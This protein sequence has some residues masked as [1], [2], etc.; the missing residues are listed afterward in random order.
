LEYNGVRQLTKR[1]DPLGRVTLFQWCK[2]GDTKS[3]TDPL[4]RTTTWHH[5][6]QRRIS[7]KQ[8][9]DG[10]KTT[11]LYEATTSRVRQVIDEKGQVAQY[12][13]TAD[14]RLSSINFA[15]TEVP[16]APVFF[17][18]DP[19]Y[20]R[21]T[22]MTDGT[23]TTFYTYVPV[24]TSP[25][26]GAAQTESIDGPLPNERIL[27]GYDQLGRRVSASV[28]GVAWSKTFD[29]AGRMIGQTNALGAFSYVYDGASYRP[30]LEV[31]PNAQTNEMAY[32]D[33]LGDNTLRRITHRIAG[34]PVS[35]FRYTQDVPAGRIASWSQ[36][37]DS[38]QPSV[39]GLEYDEADQLRSAYLTNAG[40]LSHSYAYSY[41]L[42][43]N[44]LAEQVD[45]ST[46]RASY[47]ALNQ[48]SLANGLSDASF[49]NEWDAAQRLSAVSFGNQ[50]TEFTYDG[51]GRLVGL[52]QLT[53]GSETSNRLFLWSDDAVLGELTTDGRVS[54][55]FFDQ[56]VKVEIGPNPGLFF[57]TRDH[58][59]SVRELT[60][61][62]GKIRAR[63]TYD[64]F[65]RRSRV[66][67]DAEADFGFAGMFLVSE[68]GLY[69][70]RFRMYDPETGRWL[71]RDP[72]RN[73]EVQQGFNLYTYV[74]NN[75][76]NEVDRLGL[77]CDDK[78][79]AYEQAV[80]DSDRECLFAFID[81]ST[82]C[83]HAMYNP[84]GGGAA[85]CNVLLERA[86]RKCDDGARKVFRAQTELNA[87]LKEP[88]NPGSKCSAPPPRDP[89]SY[90]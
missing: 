8:F 15:N 56:G 13:Y 7:D 10:S 74:A 31:F 68:A 39:F 5:D 55:R 18:Y 70:T 21:E 80:E 73:A 54:K 57:Y 66:Q 40:S 51:R 14:D 71:S 75:P 41:D 59:D 9:T 72:L 78:K 53:N 79:R 90:F 52:R 1:T 63:Y 58:L 83:S 88:C 35:E 82:D 12:A 38:Q 26:L 16:T 36:Q 85:Y 77:C 33:N 24:T 11:Y 86:K 43:G 42:S 17:T 69:A 4:G 81:F 34:I 37:A 60:D 45:N 76:I 65:G 2:C 87:C 61:S 28:N 67:G 19:S 48:V 89:A 32:S 44:R 47:N 27:F 25:S 64:P 62:T 50:R 30:L 46:N 22:S 6:V 23:G 49:T 84:G 20:N 3:L 29:A